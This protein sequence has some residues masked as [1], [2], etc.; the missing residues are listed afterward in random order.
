MPG[1]GYSTGKYQI[2]AVMPR[3]KITFRYI[4]LHPT[5]FSASKRGLGTAGLHPDYIRRYMEEK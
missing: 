5:A 2:I 1:F 3:E 4:P